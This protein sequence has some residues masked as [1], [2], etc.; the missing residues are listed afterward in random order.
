M[1]DSQKAEGA[2]LS[3]HMNK[4]GITFEALLKATGRRALYLSRVI[5]GVYPLTRPVC[6]ALDEM[7]GSD[8]G[9]TFLFCTTVE[10]SK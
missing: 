10:V 2:R 3:A 4:H 6:E 1:I 9:E 7:I 8:K 5:K